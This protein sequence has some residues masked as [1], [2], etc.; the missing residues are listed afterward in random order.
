M[1]KILLTILIIVFILPTNFIV[2]A[3]TSGITGDCTWT[4]EDTVLTISGNGEMGNYNY[5]SNKVPWGTSVTKVIIENGVTNIGEYS[6]YNCYELK[7]VIVSDGVLCIENFA[8]ENCESL[9]DVTIPSSVV[10]IGGYAFEGCVSLTSINIPNGVIS[11]GNMAFYGCSALSSVTIGNSVTSIEERAF[12]NCIALT[13]IILPNSVTSIGQQA[14]YNCT[15]LV[16]VTIPKSITNIK[17]YTFYGCSNL[18]DVW[19]SGSEEDSKDIKIAKYN[20]SLSKA[21]WHYDYVYS[22]DVKYGFVTN[23]EEISA[24]DA[25][26][27]LQFIVGKIHFTDQQKIIAD[28]NGDGEIT[29]TDALAILH[30]VVGKIDKFPVENN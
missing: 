1:K 10:S 8:F 21:T 26:Q 6:F 5:N 7:S 23:G 30:F 28:V 17:S 12:E 15:R 13:N 14:F 11:I 22:T 4:L 24:T 25:L 19:Y 27:I 29:A 20:T 18:S 9:T 16:S 2:F 3:E